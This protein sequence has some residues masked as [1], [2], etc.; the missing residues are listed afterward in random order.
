MRTA[1]LAILMLHDCI[2]V[3]IH[4]YQLILPKTGLVQVTV[5]D[6]TRLLVACLIKWLF[7]H[8]NP[9]VGMPDAQFMTFRH[10]GR[11]QS[12]NDLPHHGWF[13]GEGGGWILWCVF[14]NS[15]APLANIQVVHES[16][17][18]SQII[19]ESKSRSA[20]IGTCWI[21]ADFFFCKLLKFVILVETEGK[22]L[23]SS[24]KTSRCSSI[25]DP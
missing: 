10:S 24:K 9:I 13:S 19:S 11:S 17:A 2:N 1:K 12:K 16:P 25:T 7:L 15:C 23:V 18:W 20:V 8:Q 5:N 21:S 4:F 6:K 22:W 3:L 14:I